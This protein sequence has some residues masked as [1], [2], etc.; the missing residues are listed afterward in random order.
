MH[1]LSVT[2]SLL[3]ITLRHAKSANARQVTGLHIA[4]GKLASIIDD[5]VQFYWDIIAKGTIAEGARLY[6]K[7]IPVELECLS[8]HNQYLP[9]D[10]DFSCP[11]CASTL[12]KVI[13]GE[14]FDLEAL[15]VET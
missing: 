14:E 13:A 1:E 5:S 12:I 6:F 7:R 10:N 3:E 9:P 2:E 4:I 11:S 8:C 15:D